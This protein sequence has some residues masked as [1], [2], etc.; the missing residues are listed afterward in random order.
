MISSLNATGA[1]IHT[2]NVA[3][4]GTLINVRELVTAFSGLT[5]AQ[6]ANIVATNG[7]SEAQLKAIMWQAKYD[8][9]LQKEILGHYKAVIAKTADKGATDALTF[10]MSNLTTAI[11]A[12]ITAMLKWFV[13]NPVGQVILLTGAV[14]SFLTISEKMRV[15]AEEQADAFKKLQSAY[16]STKNDISG[17]KDELKT[18]QDRLAEFTKIDSLLPDQEAERAE[19]KLTEESL[20]RRLALQEKIAENQHKQMNTDAAEAL[21]NGKAYAVDVVSTRTFADDSG[22]WTAEYVNKTYMSAEEAIQHYIGEIERLKAKQKELEIAAQAPGANVES[23]NQQIEALDV[24]ISENETFLTDVVRETQGYCDSLTS[25]DYATATL[26][27]STQKYLDKAYD[28]LGVT[29]SITKAMQEQ[30]DATKSLS[31][32]LQSLKTVEDNFKKLSDVLAE[33]RDDGHVSVS[34]L[35]ELAETFSKTDGFEEFIAIVGNSSSTFEQVQTACNEMAAEWLNDQIFLGNLTEETKAMT[36]A[37]LEQMGVSNAAALA[38]AELAKQRAEASVAALKAADRTMENVAACYDEEIAAQKDATVLQQLESAKFK[39][40]LASTDFLS[41]TNN[42]IEALIQQAEAAGFATASLK[43][44]YQMKN[45]EDDPRLKGLT[46]TE[47]TWKLNDLVHD[48]MRDLDNYKV[49]FSV[50][51]SIK[52]TSSS[53][54]TTGKTAAEIAA[55]KARNAFEFEYNAWKHKLDM[56][57]ITLEEFYD[58]LGGEKGYQDYFEKQGETLEDFRKY[59]KEVFDGMRQVHEQYLSVLDYEI[60][61]LER[62]ENT[63]NDVIAKYTEKRAEIQKLIDALYAY[64]AAEGM[65]ELEI[66]SNEEYRSLLDKL[67]TIEDEVASIQ[68]EAY[69]KQQGYVNDLIDLTEEYIKQLGEDEI[70][71]LE[72]QKDRY[73]ELIQ[74]QKDLINGAREDEKYER[75]KAEKLK[76]MQKLQER[77]TALGLDGSREAMLEQGKLLE[78]LN[79]LQI[80]LDDLQKD[81]YVDSAEKALDDEEKAFH[82]AQD[83]KIKEIEDFLDDNRLINQEAINQLEGMNQ[84]M[85][86]N[87]LEYALHYTDTTRSE[88]LAMW[89]EVT[90]A[91]EKYGSVTNVASVYEDSDVN[92]KV[93]EQIN[94]LRENGQEYA[95]TTDASRKEWLANDSLKAGA[96]LQELLGVTVER[97]NGTW[98]IGDGAN[99]R[100][101]FEIYHTGAASVGGS[102]TLKQNEV[103]AKLENTETVLTQKHMNNL[104]EMLRLFNPANWV[105]SPLSKLRTN[106]VGTTSAQNQTNIEVTVPLTLYGKMDDSVLDVLHRHGRDVANLVAAKIKK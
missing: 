53:G 27:N 2:I 72:E 48:I 98:Y 101:L 47:R 105:S 52:P 50:N 33:V 103:F 97:V 39:A 54:K 28:V 90:A 56:E 106:I 42:E 73:S 19:L 22:T 7:L 93:K 81:H 46:F 89:D 80:E 100:K 67:H 18:V 88:M 83:A 40:A 99:R 41:A 78:E 6:I 66:L 102:P 61:M 60:S 37:Q 34:S 25:Q 15:S 45:V 87:L 96:E 30:S 86:D 59:S 29:E 13:T 9:E 3:Q 12:N 85:F 49:E 70:D 65:T 64:L 69:E 23:L 32:H 77:I 79:T 74:L 35:V 21:Q 36:V 76:E 75:E 58:W 5:P 16:D 84:E 10:S 51:T 63:E 95:R 38:E 11:W 71:A 57:Q 8:A 94:R 104:W 31:T 82:D 62:Q 4:K 43:A 44:L 14:A 55:E 20:K 24:T 1:A 17:L 26:R 91:A 68:E 92:N